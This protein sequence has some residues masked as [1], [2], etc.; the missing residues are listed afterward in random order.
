MESNQQIL[1]YLKQIP[2]YIELLMN[3]S[4][5]ERDKYVYLGILFVRV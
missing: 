4:T 3:N 2:T 1:I 5:R